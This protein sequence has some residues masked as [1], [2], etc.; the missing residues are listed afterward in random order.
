MRRLFIVN[1]FI[2]FLFSFENFYCQ[3]LNNSDFILKKALSLKFEKP[4]SAAYYLNKGYELNIEKK[5][6]LSAINFLLELATIHSHNVNYGEAYDGYWKALLLSEKSKDIASQTKVYQGLGWLYS[7]YKRD[8]EALKYF[9]L[10]INIRKNLPK[11]KTNLAYLQSDYFSILNLYR[12]NKNYKLAKAYLDSCYQ[13]KNSYSTN[14]KSYYLEAE[15]G[16]L[17][18]FD[19]K[20]NKSLEILNESKN[21]FEK[22]DSGYLVIIHA[23]IGEVYRL[24]GD[25]NKSISHFKES[26]NVSNKLNRHLNYKL[27]A[28][29]ALSDLY[30]EQNKLNDAYYYLK[31]AKIRNEEIFGSKSENN[32]HLL[33]IKD[34][35]RIE[36]DKQEQFINEQRIKDLENE[37]KVFFLKTTILS[38]SIIFLLLFG[39]I[40]IKHIRNKHKNEKRILSEKQNLRNQKQQEILELKNKELTESALRLIEKEEFIENLK[41]KVEGQ[42]GILDTEV[43]KRMLKTIQGSPNNN[44]KEFEARFTTI[45]QSFYNNLKNKFPQLSQTD[46]KICALVKLNLSSKDMSSLLGIS[47]E[48]VHTSRYRLRKKLGLTRKDNLEE[49]ISSF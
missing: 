38:V 37:E 17:S 46:Q 33:E 1:I 49:F 21:H 32:K 23:L 11:T 12:V 13:I 3:K 47:I 20:Y 8:N 26:L 30:F 25:F 40:W 31:L 9:N 28:Y 44:W 15:R 18:G 29:E 5:D 14:S 42:K 39:F 35:Y 45:N 19:G 22:K 36:K 16:I 34:K 6:T 4:D 48:S 24:K 27:I 10:S 43:I 7:F 41:K 2:F